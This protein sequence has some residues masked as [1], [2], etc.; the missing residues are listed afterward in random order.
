VKVIS[1]IAL[2]LCSFAAACSPEDTVPKQTWR[3]FEPRVE[4][5]SDWRQC[6]E[7]RLSGN[8]A[9]PDA[10]CGTQSVENVPCDPLPT[11]E[12]A[13]RALAA[14]ACTEAAVAALELYSKSSTPALLA[15][16][17][18]YY[19]SAQRRGRPEDLL[20]AL[21]AA[22]GALKL[23]PRSAGVHFNLAL[24]EETLGLAANAAAAWN[25]YLA[26]DSTSDW[27]REAR[28]RRD[29]MLRETAETSASRAAHVT[30]MITAAL[31]KRD[32]HAIELAVDAG[33]IT[34][35]S[36]LKALATEPARREDA[37]LLAKVLSRDGVDQYPLDIVKGG[38]DA[39][40]FID[41]VRR[42]GG[43][44]E[45][46]DYQ[47]ILNA[48]EPLR[49]EAERRHY[50]YPLAL[51]YLYR[52]YCLQN[53]SQYIEA[54]ADC[55]A[56]LRI[57]QRI[58]NREGIARASIRR[59]GILR[60]VGDKRRAWREAFAVL[61]D[62]RHV[63]ALTDRQLMLG[64]TAETVLSLHHPGTAF[65]YQ[66]IAV[67][68]SQ[69]EAG[70]TTRVSALR[71][72]ARI[73]VQ[74][75]R[76][77][78]ARADLELASRLAVAA[79]DGGERRSLQTRLHEVQ[80]QLFLATD[81]ARAIAEFKTAF[82]LSNSEESATYRAGVL[83]QSATA[84]LQAGHPLAARDDQRR[85]FAV[86]RSE[87]AGILARRGAEDGEQFWTVYFSRFQDAYRSYVE[88]Q[89]ADKQPADAFEYAERA[90]AAEPLDL[91][92]RHDPSAVAFRD[93]GLAGVQ[94][95]LPEGTVVVEYSVH[96]SATYAWIISRHDFQLLPLKATRA[97]VERWVEALQLAEQNHDVLEFRAGL[98][99]PYVA[100]IREPL[101]A[102][103]ALRH[104][105][106]V[107]RLVFISDEPL[108]ALP[109]ASLHNP[110]TGQYLLEETAPIATD[111]S[112][113][114]YL[115]SLDRD[116]KLPREPS[117]SILA[118][119]NPAFDETA[120]LLKDYGPLPL[121]KR[122]ARDVAALYPRSEVRTDREPTIA[123]FLARSRDKTV[124]HIAAH[125]IANPDEP[126]RSQLLLAAGD[127]RSGAF[128]ATE[129]LAKLKLDRTRLV[130]LS[131]CKSAGGLPI[132]PEGV[133]PLVRPWLAAGVPAVVG[134]L[135]NVNDATA[136]EL[137]VSF[138]AQ[139]KSGKDAATSLQ[140][141]QLELLH[142]ANP[143]LR[144]ALAW[145]AFQV[146][147]HASSPFE[148]P[149]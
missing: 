54:L 136:G 123:D 74:L 4:G 109:F 22:E 26:I 99:A 106:T 57:C 83:L 31:A 33:A 61:R 14:P 129:L 34:A 139:L 117:P 64:D 89:I 2:A 40:G 130:V 19:L 97:D 66:D 84:Q 135:W 55:D 15:L 20:L 120:P 94:A 53:A 107:R 44:W 85:A 42:A 144:P 105:P 9:M 68:E 121:A 37:Q 142:H 82:D 108:H 11:V 100:L 48:L 78:A 35:Y 18:A 112:L 149:P 60:I 143:G 45:N 12:V 56:A 113:A 52:G 13:V 148:S 46:P 5:V 140:Q 30:E 1:L 146:I 73:E 39:L 98:S 25:D 104:T 95:R 50:Q 65:R 59:F 131:A 125:A 111:G 17:A 126:Y 23:D 132:G 124:V 10:R 8:H 67:R 51:L 58:G 141:A 128:A 77:E 41:S 62:Q 118:I 16:P 133:G 96:A 75:G 80:G 76:L 72:R 137:F 38:S 91:I 145:G 134:S 103:R 119:G 6:E 7:I 114:L 127:G 81:P 27:A 28:T 63:I 47:A 87:E 90:R 49:A 86:L 79:K 138:H 24:T 110:E 69:R 36:V 29:R 32:E 92:A 101:Q 93:L 70:P 102:V 116:R 115:Y 3:T 122:E 43:G 71:G 21:D 147:G 88:R